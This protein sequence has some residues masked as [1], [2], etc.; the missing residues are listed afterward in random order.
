MT[1]ADPLLWLN[2]RPDAALRILQSLGFPYSLAGVFR[3]F[4]KALR[5]AVYRWI[6]RNRYRWFGRRDACRLPTPV[7]RERFLLAFGKS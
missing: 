2:L 5:D 7:E 3:V 6:A 1:L 4:P